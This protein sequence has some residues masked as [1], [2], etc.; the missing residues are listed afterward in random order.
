MCFK[1]LEFYYQKIT[2]NLK[3]Q[4]SIC[5][6]FD[7]RINKLVLEQF[8]NK[9]IIFQARE[10]SFTTLN[11]KSDP[12]LLHRLKKKLKLATKP[13]LQTIPLVYSTRLEIYERVSSH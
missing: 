10:K 7:A 2:K 8:R 6:L 4:L 11:A 3:L 9:R 1:C 12:I 13:L 5:F